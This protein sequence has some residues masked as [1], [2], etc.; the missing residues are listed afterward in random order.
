MSS[1]PARQELEHAMLVN[2]YDMNPSLMFIHSSL[3]MPIDDR[4]P[5]LSA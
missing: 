1:S 2:P 5:E 4:K 3:V